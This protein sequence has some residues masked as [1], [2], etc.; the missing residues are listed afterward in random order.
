M[1]GIA[2]DLYQIARPVITA[3]ATVE[4]VVGVVCFGSYALGTADAASDIDLYVLCETTLIPDA[5]RRSLFERLAGVS[6]LHLQ[7]ST[8]GWEN[9][10]APQSDQL[11]VGQ[12]GFDL[13][14]NTGAWVASVVHRVITQGALSLPEMPFRPYTLLGTAGTGHPAVRSARAGEG[15]PCTTLAL[16]GRVEGEPNPRAFAHNDGWPGGI[17]RLC[18][19]T[20]WAGH[21]SISVGARL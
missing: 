17:T 19:A 5:T 20:N 16:S 11:K 2:E 13:S 8:P 9:A 21:V 4:A 10:W 15:P 18:A 12:M 6:D 14:Y 3:L 1:I 7:H